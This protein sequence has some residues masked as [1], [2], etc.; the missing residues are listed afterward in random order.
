MSCDFIALANQGVQALRPYQPG[1][2]V[3][4]LQRELGLEKIVK[5]A[6]NEN[7]LGLSPMVQSRLADPKLLSELTRYPDGA[8]FSLKQKLADVYKLS[9]DQ[10]TLG[11]GS[12]DVLNLIGLS[13]INP[14]SSVIYSQHAFVVYSIMT[15]YLGAKAIE[16]AAKNYGYD[17]DAMLAAITDDTSVIFIA[18]PNNPTGTWLSHQAM[19]T[20][21]QQVPEHI[22]VVLDE[23]Y[24]EYI[25]EVGD[26]YADGFALLRAFPNLVLTR[27]FSKAFGLAGLR[28][29]FAASSPD[30][31]DILNRV[32]EPFNVNILAQLAAQTVLDDHDYLQ[33]SIAVNAAGRIQLETALAALNLAFIPSQGNFITFDT[34]RDADAVYH[35]LLALGV[36]VRPIAGYGLP[37]HLRVSIGLAEEN[38][39]FID[40][41]HQLR[42]QAKI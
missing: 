7:P 10:L 36:I 9:P 32:R 17:L 20:F 13:Y 39:A 31:A 24:S 22:I 34:A 27:S 42:A 18:N 23:A 21:M 3:E 28:C 37:Q 2:P 29:G 35:D 16:V 25:D 14:N 33:R 12:N 5:L 15:Q 8:A 4:E 30:I 41:L 11:N 19:L 1:K 26:D 6:S 40:A 38:Q